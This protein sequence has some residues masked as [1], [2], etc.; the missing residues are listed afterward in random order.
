VRS[1]DGRVPTCRV[2]IFHPL[3]PSTYAIQTEDVVKALVEDC[4][5]LNVL[6][7]NS[8]GGCHQPAVFLDVHISFHSLHP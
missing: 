8:F 3:P 6:V 1:D 2:P 7:T 5:D 4:R